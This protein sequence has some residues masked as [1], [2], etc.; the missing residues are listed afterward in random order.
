MKIFVPM[1]VQAA[2][3]SDVLSG[4]RLG[5][6]RSGFHDRRAEQSIHTWCV[7]ALLAGQ[8]V[9]DLRTVQRTQLGQVKRLA[10]KTLNLKISS[11][12][13]FPH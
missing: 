9:P 3:E 12:F 1:P 5:A 2:G 8:I 10:Y 11:E 7:Q 13:T 4:A 6:L